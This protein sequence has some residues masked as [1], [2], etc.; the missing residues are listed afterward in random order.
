MG[1]RRQDREEQGRGAAAAAGLRGLGPLGMARA[2]RPPSDS[3]ARSRPSRPFAARSRVRL[4]TCPTRVQLQSPGAGLP[5][6]RA[7]ALGCEQQRLQGPP[8]RP[9]AEAK[10]DW[11]V[12]R[13]ERKGR[14]E[15]GRETPRAPAPPLRAPSPPPAPPLPAQARPRPALAPAPSGH[16]GPGPTAHRSGR[17]TGQGAR[18]APDGRSAAPPGRGRRL[19]VEPRR[20]HSHPQPRQRPQRIWNFW[21]F[22]LVPKLCSRWRPSVH[23]RETPLLKKRDIDAP[24]GSGSKLA[25]EKRPRLFPREYISYLGRVP[26]F[27]PASVFA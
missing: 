8:P 13:G 18:S 23:S 26:Q 12:R 14:R 16:S 10:K 1:A 4:R 21:N 25:G 7:A 17:S 5:P 22:C 11:R 2:R 3:R 19:A 15:G 20:G 24:G 6:G 27:L 9:A